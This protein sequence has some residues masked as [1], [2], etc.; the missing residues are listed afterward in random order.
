MSRRIHFPPFHLDVADE[1][2]WCGDAPVRVRRKTFAVL[3]YLAQHPNR[4]VTKAELLQAVWPDTRV[5]EV[6]LKVCV[7]ELRA[8]L[9][10]NALTPRFIQ[11]VHG[12]GYR[13]IGR[14]GAQPAKRSPAVR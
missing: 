12:R 10:D 14:L 11:T 4:L 6:V 2:L 5:T 9:G 8:A 13:F 3:R 7:R 1:R